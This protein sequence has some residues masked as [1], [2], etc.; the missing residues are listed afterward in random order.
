MGIGGRQG[1]G[2]EPGGDDGGEEEVGAMAGVGCLGLRAD[3]CGDWPKG[4][5]SC[6]SVAGSS[7]KGR[8]GAADREE[9]LRDDAREM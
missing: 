7:R 6:R 1:T 5:G 2:A 3:G 4:G 8:M 9:E